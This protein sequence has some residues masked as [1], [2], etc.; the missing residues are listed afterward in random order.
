VSGVA[1]KGRDVIS[2]LDFSRPELGSLFAAADEFIGPPRPRKDLADR[3]VATAF[4]EPSTRT[5]LS[6]T[7]A[8]LRLGAKVIDL[9]GGIGVDP[10][11]TKADLINKGCS[12][13]VEADLS[14]IIEST[15]NA[16]Q[17]RATTIPPTR[18][19]RLSCRSFAS[20]H[21]ARRTAISTCD[22]F[23]GFASRSAGR[24]KPRPR[25]IPSS[26]AAPSCRARCTRS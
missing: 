11:H 3:I 18:A 1:W 15:V 7:T 21:Q 6:F 13:I 20:A 17:L 10:I 5:R 9:V 2:I 12:R 4:F 8:A 24:S 22:T 16:G 14:E 26:S 23:G 25:A 19:A